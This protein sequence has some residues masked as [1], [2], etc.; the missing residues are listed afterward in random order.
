MNPL[1]LTP[2]AWKVAELCSAQEQNW[3]KTLLLC[4][5]CLPK[6]VS[7]YADHK[8]GSW[9]IRE[10]SKLW[11]TWD[12]PL[13]IK[14][15]EFNRSRMIHSYTDHE[16]KCSQISLILWRAKIE[17]LDGSHLTWSIYQVGLRVLYLLYDSKIR[18]LL[19]ILPNISI[20]RP[21][22]KNL[23][24]IFCQVSEDF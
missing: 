11:L 2:G 12:Y 1:R 23:R 4:L 7:I 22:F 19:Y 16:V 17:S 10:R 14:Q 13:K 9:Q 21:S 20:A 6:Y 3:I 18:P 8:L 15:T 5:Q 24:G